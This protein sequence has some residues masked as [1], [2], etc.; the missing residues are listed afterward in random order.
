MLFVRLTGIDYPEGQLGG[1]VWYWSRTHR[2]TNYFTLSQLWWISNSSD[3]ITLFH[4][5][6][7]GANRWS[8]LWGFF[9]A[10]FELSY[11]I[12][13]SRQSGQKKNPNR[14]P[15]EW[16]DAVPK[17][18]VCSSATVMRPFE[19]WWWRRG[20]GTR[21][22]TLQLLSACAESGHTHTGPTQ[23]SAVQLGR[24]AGVLSQASRLNKEWRG[25][26]T[27]Q[28]QTPPRVAKHTHA[29]LA[30]SAVCNTHDAQR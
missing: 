21:T 6:F 30:A 13:R 17:S 16:K 28:P 14:N 5:F 26:S 7:W 27:I 1:C 10:L 24:H 8:Y 12:S 29:A 4:Y 25:G 3:K 2:H 15:P 20:A 18:K 23:L 22:E 11:E 19:S 9:I